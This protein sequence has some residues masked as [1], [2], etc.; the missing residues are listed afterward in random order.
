[1]TD[2]EQK[3]LVGLTEVVRNLN[4]AV[5]IQNNININQKNIN[6]ELLL[7]IIELRKRV[8]KLEENSAL[9]E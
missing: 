7:A 6:E 9:Q 2:K 4:E 5:G 8:S 1:M 3:A